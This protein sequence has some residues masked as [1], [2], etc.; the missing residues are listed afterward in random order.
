M[1]LFRVNVTGDIISRKGNKG[2]IWVLWKSIAAQH[3]ECQN[4]FMFSLNLSWVDK[5]ANILHRGGWINNFGG[6]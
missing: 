1:R 5:K 6:P 3:Q 2:F 4:D